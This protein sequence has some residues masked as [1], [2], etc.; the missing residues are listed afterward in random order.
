MIRAG[1]GLLLAVLSA[2]PAMAQT[3]PSVESTLA[4]LSKPRCQDIRPMIARTPPEQRAIDESALAEGIKQPDLLIACAPGLP[5]V[6]EQRRVRRVAAVTCL[7]MFDID[8]KGAP[9]KIETRCNAASGLPDTSEQWLSYFE[10][11]AA[12]AISE[13]VARNIYEP[14]STGRPPGKRKDAAYVVDLRIDPPVAV[15]QP[16]P[17]ERSVSQ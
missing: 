12:G 4:R 6:F 10:A 11:V 13:A 15:P 16:E 14:V 9:Q 1:I 3:P 7:S 17:F 2:A 8:D 5:D